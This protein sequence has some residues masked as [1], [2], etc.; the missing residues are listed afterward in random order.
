MKL[1]NLLLLACAAFTSA[2]GAALADDGMLAPRQAPAKTIPVPT[3]V[4][5]QLQKL[6]A[7]P[8]NPVW[9]VLWTTGEQW[10]TAADAQAAKVMQALPA[11]RASGRHGAG[12]DDQ[13][14]EGAYRDAQ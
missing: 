2:S 1:T 10:R 4:S 8:L 9:N 5:P 13:R 3:E 12:I 7:A 6:I 14:R 11:M